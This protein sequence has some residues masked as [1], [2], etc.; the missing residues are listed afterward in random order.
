M[1]ETKSGLPE[2]EV[3]QIVLDAI[4]ELAEEE[5]L[6]FAVTLETGLFAERGESG[7]AFDSLTALELLTILEDKLGVQMEEPAKIFAEVRTG[8]DIVRLV[9]GN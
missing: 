7:L 1:S 5:E 8:D 4:L 6:P 2:T 3:R 9:L